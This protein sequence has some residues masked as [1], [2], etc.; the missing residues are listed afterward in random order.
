MMQYLLEHWQIIAGVLYLLCGIPCG[1]A[2]CMGASFA[3]ASMVEVVLSSV[4][5]VFLWPVFLIA[6]LFF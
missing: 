6:L 3:G 1:I 4:A 5:A 2:T